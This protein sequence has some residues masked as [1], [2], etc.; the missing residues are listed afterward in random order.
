MS[1]GNAVRALPAALLLALVALSGV[2]ATRPDSAAFHLR[3]LRSDPAADTTLAAAPTAIRL[4]FTE[5][6]QIAVTT[7]ALKNAAGAAITTAKPTRAA[8]K[9]A[10]VV[11]I[12]QGTLAPGAYHV[13]WKT[14]SHDGHAVSGEFNFTLKSAGN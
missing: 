3:L 12:V 7:V 11:A 2:A 6:P 9:D 5:A 1:R 10:P 8:D 13:A 4:W 14:M